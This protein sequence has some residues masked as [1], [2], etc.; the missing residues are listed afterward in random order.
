MSQRIHENDAHV[1]TLQTPTQHKVGSGCSLSRTPS[2]SH[3]SHFHQPLWPN[4]KKV[5]GHRPTGGNKLALLQGKYRTLCSSHQVGFNMEFLVHL[6]G[7][8]KTHAEPSLLLDNLFQETR[9]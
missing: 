8:T 7:A 9:S 3:T 4:Q 5:T 1:S 6:T 2:T